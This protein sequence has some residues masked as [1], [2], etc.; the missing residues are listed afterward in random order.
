MAEKV[1]KLQFI[2]HRD[3]IAV[4]NYLTDPDRFVSVHPLIYQMTALP[5]GDYLVREKVSLG[6]FPYRFSYTAS[7]SAF[8]D[9]IHI[10]ASVMGLT[11]INMLFRFETA[12]G[13]TQVTEKLKIESVLPITNFMASFFEKQ[14]RQLFDNIEKAL[15]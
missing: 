4:M 15:T 2:V 12:S 3:R 9:E 8:P 13:S 7:I 1:T 11:H 14:H 5:G 6:L 10:S